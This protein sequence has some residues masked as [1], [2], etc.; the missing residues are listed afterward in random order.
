[1]SLSADGRVWAADLSAPLFNPSLVWVPGDSRTA[2][3]WARNDS[4]DPGRLTASIEGVATD[5]LMETGALTVT[6]RGGGG[7][8]TPTDAAGTHRLLQ[9]STLPPGGAVRVAVTVAFDPEAGPV[10]QTASLDLR[11]AVSLEQR[12]D[13]GDEGGLPNTGGAL[14]RRSAGRPVEAW[15]LR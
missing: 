12:V 15:R 4:A 8:W 5:R 14:R 13:P 9:V 6:A 11:L 7:H 2:R 1:L 3:F 10:S